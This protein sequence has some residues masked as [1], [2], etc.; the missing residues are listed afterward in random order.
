[1]KKSIPGQEN[2]FRYVSNF[3]RL[4]RVQGKENMKIKKGSNPGIKN[5]NPKYY[6]CKI[7]LKWHIWDLYLQI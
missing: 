6:L 5:T 4:H 1:L 3:S 7:I 2:T